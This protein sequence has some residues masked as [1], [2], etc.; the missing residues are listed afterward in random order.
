MDLLQHPNADN[1]NGTTFLFVCQIKNA[2]FLILT[3][4]CVFCAKK[5]AAWR[6]TGPRAGAIR[7]QAIANYRNWGGVFAHAK[8]RHV[9]SP[10]PKMGVIEAHGKIGQARLILTM[11]YSRSGDRE[12]RRGAAFSRGPVPRG[13][14]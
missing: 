5:K 13:R 6:G 1:V 10:M 11:G 7:D 8:K 14:C 3:G 9:F 12:L 4:L 2:M